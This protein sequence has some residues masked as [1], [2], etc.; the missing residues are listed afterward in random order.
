MMLQISLQLCDGLELLINVC[1]L[2]GF[3]VLYGTHTFCLYCNGSMERSVV[4]SLY[5]AIYDS[6]VSCV[7]F[8]R[9]RELVIDAVRLPPANYNY[10]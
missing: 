9:V 10:G 4:S 3:F 5:E 8:E 1:L 2:C 7:R 6:S